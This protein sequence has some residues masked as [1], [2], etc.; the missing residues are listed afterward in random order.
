M[1]FFVMLQGVLALVVLNVLVSR[2]AHRRNNAHREQLE[3]DE[4]AVRQLDYKILEAQR[5]ENNEREKI[6][7]LK[8]SIVSAENLLETVEKELEAARKAPPDLYFIFDRL[9]PRPGIIWEV[10][11]SRNMDVPLNARSAAVWKQPRRYLIAAKTP[12]EA[13][14]RA[15]QRFFEKTGLKVDSVS[16]CALFA[17]KRGEG[18]EDGESGGEGRR[19]AVE[20]VR[21]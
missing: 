11:V 19:R 20:R 14:D 17:P 18:G 1:T 13:H 21:E 5:R 8:D 4:I 6:E 10:M 9:E 2:F 12:K 15:T 7:A 16:P 3:N